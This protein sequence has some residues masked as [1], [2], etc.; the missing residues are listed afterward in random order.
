MINKFS[1]LFLLSNILFYSLVI[2]CA[3]SNNSQLFTDD[4]LNDDNFFAELDNIIN[5]ENNNIEENKLS[6]DSHDNSNVKES[7][8]NKKRKA[9]SNE[10]NYNKKLEIKEL[11]EKLDR[12]KRENHERENMLKKL[13]EEKEK[14]LSN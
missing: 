6:A 9:V 13:V 4:F 7:K 11:K 12:L 1:Y 8:T 10:S 5:V 2:R 14:L 3:N